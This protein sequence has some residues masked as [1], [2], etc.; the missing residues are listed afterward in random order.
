MTAKTV[1]FA[2][3]LLLGALAAPLPVTAQYF[4]PVLL[5]VPPATHDYGAPKP[6]SRP[7]PDKPKSADD[8]L[9]RPSRPGI[10]KVRHSCRIRLSSNAADPSPQVGM[11]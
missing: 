1:R 10:I 2:A 5:V 4:P 7:P 9:R 3:G 8:P 6:A 11:R